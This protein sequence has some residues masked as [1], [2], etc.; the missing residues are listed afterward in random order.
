MNPTQAQQLINS[1]SSIAQA[2]FKVEAELQEIRKILVK[3]LE[4]RQPK[5]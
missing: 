4:E 5:T 2:L 3:D 1:V